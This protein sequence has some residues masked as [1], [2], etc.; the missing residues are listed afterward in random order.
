[1]PGP[2]VAWGAV[3][4]DA[5]DAERVAAFWG[6]LLDRPWRALAGERTGW[7]QVAP[8]AAGGPGLTIQPVAGG[9]PVRTPLHLDLWVDDV[10]AAVARVVELGGRRGDHA[11]TLDRGR[12]QTAHDPEGH[13]FCLLSGPV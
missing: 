12:I 9:P 6:G 7:F 8:T 4:I 10:E 13:V 5:T 1:V 3:V 11:E 2:I